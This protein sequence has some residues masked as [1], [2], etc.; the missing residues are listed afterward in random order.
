MLCQP[1]AHL[2]AVQLRRELCQALLRAPLPLPP[3]P[4]PQPHLQAVQQRRELCQALLWPPLLC[5]VKTRS[6]PRVISDTA[7]LV[8]IYALP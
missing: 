5:N 8:P 4:H 1:C 7:I 2:Q 6:S 3:N